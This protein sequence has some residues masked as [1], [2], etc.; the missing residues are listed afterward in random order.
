VINGVFYKQVDEYDILDLW[1]AIEEK[2]REAEKNDP[3]IETISEPVKENLSEEEILKLPYADR[4]AR[5]NDEYQRTTLST[6][7][8]YIE[9]YKRYGCVTE[10]NP[11]PLQE[12]F[13]NNSTTISGGVRSIRCSNS[14]KEVVESNSTGQN[15]RKTTYKDRNHIA[16]K[17][18]DFEQR[19]KTAEFNNLSPKQQEIANMQ[20][21]TENLNEK[22]Q[23]YVS[24]ILKL[25]N[26]LSTN[27]T[28]SL[29]QLNQKIEN[30]KEQLKKK[31]KSEMKIM[32]KIKR[33][34]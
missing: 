4:V 32:L 20:K 22:K 25:E 31:R 26:E 7:L 19:L 23:N 2:L 17:E 16:N 5:L 18:R 10:I 34:I 13:N 30:Q 33:K 11:F 27:S 12:S 6:L 29:E 21:E 14:V 3:Q 15:V 28:K 8:Q 9:N 1:N 24:K